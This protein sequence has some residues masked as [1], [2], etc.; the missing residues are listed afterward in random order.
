MRLRSSRDRDE[1][2]HPMLQWRHIGAMFLLAAMRYVASRSDTVRATGPTILDP[3]IL[4]GITLSPALVARE[5]RELA[6]PGNM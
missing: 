2:S 5:A 4:T 6:K 1:N 3:P